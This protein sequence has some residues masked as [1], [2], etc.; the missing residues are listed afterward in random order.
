MF[1]LNPKHL[2]KS[3]S[4]LFSAYASFAALKFLFRTLVNELK[5]FFPPWVRS[6]IYSKLR[7]Y[8]FKPPSNDNLTLFI[9]KVI[10]MEPN[11]AYDKVEVYLG[12]KICPSDSR[13]ELIKSVIGFRIE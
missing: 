5:E 6:Y 11:E 13:L 9:N 3:L 8:F 7:K 10:G 4:S 1:P 2:P 12:S